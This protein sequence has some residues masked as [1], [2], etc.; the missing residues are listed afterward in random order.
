MKVYFDAS[1]IIASLLSPS[2]GSSRLFRS[3]KEKKITGVTSQ[4]AVDE[5][6]SKA[7]KIG[8]SKNEIENFLGLSSI[9]VRKSITLEEISPYVNLVDAEDAHIIAGAILSRCDYLVSLD[10]K[11]ILRK[12]IR[13][14]FLPLRIVSPKELIKNIYN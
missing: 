7:E 14:K 13:E 5:V 6:L 10:K 8:K 2:G 11:H 1:V 12:D 3:I 4:T 9:L